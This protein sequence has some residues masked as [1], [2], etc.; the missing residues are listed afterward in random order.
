MA[1]RDGRAWGVGCCTLGAAPGVVFGAGGGPGRDGEGR[2]DRSAARTAAVR[3]ASANGSS[4]IIELG[5]GD[6]EALSCINT[7][8]DV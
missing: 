7:A 6:A 4:S 5:C 8:N 1:L 2:Y 3:S